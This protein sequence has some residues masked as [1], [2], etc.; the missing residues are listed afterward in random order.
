[1]K[2]IL[3]VVL[4]LGLASPAHAQEAEEERGFSLMEEGAKL[5]FDGLRK[6][7]APALEE[8]EGLAEDMGPQLRQ[9]MNEMG[10]ALADLMGQIDDMTN[11]GPPE[12]LPNGDIL[13]P[14]KP[15]APTLDL[16]GEIEI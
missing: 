5:F 11:Y 3:A 2:H 15:D 9:L 7:M 4:A 6:E 12:I 16:D 14:R 1:M 8:L 13:I 10:P